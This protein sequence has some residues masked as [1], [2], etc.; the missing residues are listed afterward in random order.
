MRISYLVLLLLTAL[1]APFAPAQTPEDL[2]EGTKLEWDSAN[3]IW[4]FKWWGR[5]GRTYFIQHSENLLDPWQWVPVIES[6][7]ESV[8]EWGFTTTGDKFFL[9]LKYSDLPTND[10]WNADFDG[11]KVSNYSELWNGTD[12]LKYADTDGD[13]MPDDWEAYNGLDPNNPA[14]AS[15]DLDSDGLSNLGEYQAGTYPYYSDS[16][17]DG[18][19]DGDEVNVYGSNPL[20]WDSDGD[21]LSDG[22]EVTYG[23]NPAVTTDTTTDVDDDGLDWAGEQSWGTD[24][25]NA[26]TDGDG[27]SDGK[28]AEQG[29]SPTNGDSDGDSVPD[30]FEI[31]FKA[32]TSYYGRYKYGFATYTATTPPK[33]YLKEFI[34]WTSLIGGNPESGPIGIGPGTFTRH[35]DPLTGD[36][37]SETTGTG[38]YVPS[39]PTSPTS[40]HDTFDVYGY[41]DPPNEEYDEP[42]TVEADGTLSDEHTT[43]MLRQNT[44][45]SMPAYSGTFWSYGSAYQDTY[46]DELWYSLQKMKYK[47]AFGKSIQ[48]T[49]KWVEMF[50]PE[51]DPNT[52]DD[53]SQNPMFE[54]KT[55]SGT[56]AETSEFEIDPYQTSPT[57]DGSYGV[58]WVDSVWVDYT[59]PDTHGIPS[60]QYSANIRGKTHFVCVK[61][62]GD[63]VLRAYLSTWMP[64]AGLNKITWECSGASITSSASGTDPSDTLTAK[65]S[66][67]TPGKYPVTMKIDGNVVWEGIVWVV[68]ANGS[69]LNTPTVALNHVSG[70]LTIDGTV[71]TGAYATLSQPYQFKFGITPS[72]IC[73]KNADVPELTGA[74]DTAGDAQI[75]GVSPYS[76]NRLVNGAPLRWD[77]SRRV[78]YHFL[79]PNLIPYGKMTAGYGS[80]YNGQ[81][82]ADLVTVDFPTSPLIGNDDASHSIDEDNDPYNASNKTNLTHA[83]GEITSLDPPN[84]AFADA[85]GGTG[86][87]FQEDDLFQEFARVQL[88][89]TWYVISDPL[90]W[91]LIMKIKFQN[92]QWVD[93]GTTTGPGN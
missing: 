74:R 90:P 5:Q 13:G 1:L 92:G 85:G 88:G 29:T 32:E 77:V 4:R 3:S 50:R 30:G 67:S 7:N 66:S 72:D 18:V 27:I 78:K 49:L 38:G 19:S 25:N 58:V 86:F 83:V 14:D 11:D 22:F 2:N 68:W 17:W 57:K 75:D 81:P 89:A 15:G 69:I 71:S 6:G 59:D 40:K 10:P 16:D 20:A 45:N 48:A 24:P 70:I 79:N 76:N 23:L 63:I 43:D 87:T 39:T 54:G 12:P 56:G 51:D 8:R 46:T 41:D 80:I 55:W 31:T 37:T 61:N 9:R 62:T 42:G 91:K 93:D 26:D 73:D 65:M 34:S 36:F 64:D 35:I 28:E 53:E 84:A 44:V 60:N 52:Q 21:G 33:R 47:F 82:S